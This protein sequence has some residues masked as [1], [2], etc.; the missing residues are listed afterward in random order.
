MRPGRAHSA[1]LHR[2]FGVVLL[3]AAWGAVARQD[4]PFSMS[5][6]AVVAAIVDGR[7]GD[8]GGSIGV[9]PLPSVIVLVRAQA[10]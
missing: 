10:T 1:Q 7:A 2:A 8:P 3:G 5:V 9:D 4:L 6:V